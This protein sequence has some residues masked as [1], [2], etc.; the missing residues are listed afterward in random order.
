MFL[1]LARSTSSQG[2]ATSQLSL[3]DTIHRYYSYAH[4]RLIHVYDGVFVETRPIFLVSA[5][6]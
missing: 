6:G 4:L 5:N 3:V 1:S 2:V